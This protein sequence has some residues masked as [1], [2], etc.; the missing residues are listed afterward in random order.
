MNR[1][2]RPTEKKHDEISKKK[3]QDSRAKPTL[4]RRKH[5]KLGKPLVGVVVLVCG[6]TVAWALPT[7]ICPLSRLAG[8]GW[9]EGG[10]CPLFRIFASHPHPNL[11]PPDGG[12]NKVAVTEKRPSEKPI[13]SFSDDLSSIFQ[14]LSKSASAASTHS[15]DTHNKPVRR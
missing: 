8:E 5:P 12:R 1:L 15:S 13:S 2:F 11:P 3:Q 14:T 9:G 10:S 6:I 7:I 4:R